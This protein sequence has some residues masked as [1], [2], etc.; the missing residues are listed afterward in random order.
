M[1]TRTPVLHVP[2]V[3][4]RLSRRTLRVR[5]SRVRP[6]R[7]VAPAMSEPKP[8]L[9]L[10]PVRPLS[11]DER[12]AYIVAIKSAL[13]AAYRQ[14]HSR[15]HDMLPHINISGD[16]GGLNGDTAQGPNSTEDR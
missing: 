12:E 1:G 7:N 15:E 8:V 14:R 2:D 6:T 4:D 16:F 10:G 5:P 3:P 9:T 13:V 11:A